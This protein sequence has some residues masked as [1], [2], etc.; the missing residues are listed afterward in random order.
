[1][2]NTRHF[3]SETGKDSDF[4]GLNEKEA[5]ALAEKR[6]VAHRVVSVNGKTRPHWMDYRADR[7]NFWLEKRK[8]VKT[9]RY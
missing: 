5:E 8:V 9:T 2:K 1:M 4:I 6:G 7:I 3:R